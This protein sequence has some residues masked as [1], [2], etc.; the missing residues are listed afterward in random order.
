MRLC[1]RIIDQ[2]DAMALRTGLAAHM[3]HAEFESCLTGGIRR[4][5]LNRAAI[6]ANDQSEPSS[7]DPV[8]SQS[9]PRSQ[10]GSGVRESAAAVASRGFRLLKIPSGGIS[11]FQTATTLQA[12]CRKGY[13]HFFRALHGP[14]VAV[15]KPPGSACAAGIVA[16]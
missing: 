14:R 8:I 9:A 11:P 4:R 12:L 6:D 16:L 10:R 3:S 1:T 5:Q 15:A 2:S 13:P 7:R